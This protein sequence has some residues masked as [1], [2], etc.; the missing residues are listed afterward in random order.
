M[1][2]AS[3][4]RHHLLGLDEQPWG[5]RVNDDVEFLVDVAEVES[6]VSKPYA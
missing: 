3:N 5:Y 1:L 2:V 4:L 6:G